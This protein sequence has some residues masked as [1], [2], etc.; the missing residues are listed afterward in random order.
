MFS[1]SPVSEARPARRGGGAGACR[2]AAGH[3]SSNDTRG[4]GAGASASAAASVVSARSRLDDMNSRF[5]RFFAG[6]GGS[7]AGTGAASCATS[8]SKLRERS[9]LPPSLC[10]G[11]GVSGGRAPVLGCD[12]GIPA[13]APA[14]RPGTWAL[15]AAKGSNPSRGRPADASRARATVFSSRTTRARANSSK[16]V[17][18]PSTPVTI[19]VLPKLNYLT[20]IPNP[21]ARSPTTRVTNPAIKSPSISNS[22]SAALQQ[23]PM[24]R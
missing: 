19:R 15:W 1:P 4:S 11:A 13:P 20:G 12:A 21:I 2:S 18:T 14:T 16:P 9:R 24:P 5:L 7:G 17:Q 22:P 10:H 3:A 23:P 6:S 8:G